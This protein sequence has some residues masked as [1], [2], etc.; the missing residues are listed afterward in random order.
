MKSKIYNYFAE[1][2]YEL[3]NIEY[4]S[5]EFDELMNLNLNMINPKLNNEPLMITNE[6]N[7]EP[8][9]ITNE[10]NNEPLMI[11]NEPLMITN[12]LNNEP[13]M[14]TNELLDT[15]VIANENEIMNI[16]NVTIYTNKMGG[17]KKNKNENQ[18]D[19]YYI[20]K[21]HNGEKYDIIFLMDGHGELGKYIT[22]SFLRFVNIIL[23]EFENILD[24]PGIINNLLNNFNDSPDILKFGKNSGSSFTMIID[25]P[26][27]IISTHIGGSLAFIKFNKSFNLQFIIDGVMRY[28]NSDYINLT[29][30][31]HTG[32]NIIEVRRIL[33]NN[34]CNINYDI[35]SEYENMILNVWDILYLNNNTIYQKINIDDKKHMI[36][37][38]DIKN[39]Y[40]HFIT[41]ENDYKLNITRTIGDRECKFVICNPTITILMKPVNQYFKYT[42][43]SGTDSFHNCYSDDDFLK[44]FDIVSSEKICDNVYDKADK[45]F[46][47]TNIDNMS[48]IILK[49]TNELINDNK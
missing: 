32:M 38:K 43:I 44:L 13:L 23:D 26:T 6:L 48:I 10:L 41:D 20:K 33:E 35:I 19:I 7:N 21:N 49:N 27:K 29:P 45:L 15:L 8:L 24:N 34:K 47:I 46:G 9:M 40:K 11:T 28:I 36:Y 42:I 16:N 31:D 14:I 17:T 4:Y 37:K 12:E 18:D 2:N 22:T 30:G 3:S 39:N 1:V 25:C 5:V